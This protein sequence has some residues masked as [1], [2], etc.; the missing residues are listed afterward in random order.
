MVDSGYKCPC[1][2]N[3]DDAKFKLSQFSRYSSMSYPAKFDELN[4]ITCSNCCFSFTDYPV[5]ENV[6]G[7][8]YKDHYTGRSVKSS[9]WNSR[10]VRSKYQ[11][12]SRSIAQLS[13]ISQFFSWNGKKVLE[14]G[15]SNANLLID[16]RNRG[17]LFEAYIVEPQII[18]S[19]YYDANNINVVDMDVF[20]ELDEAVLEQKY[21]LV[22]MSHSLEHFNSDKISVVFNNVYKL[23]SDGGIFFV[24]VPNADLCKYDSDLER[25]APHLSFFSERSIH[26]FMENSSFKTLYSGAFGQSQ[27]DNMEEAIR[28]DNG[29]VQSEYEL[30]ST[31]EIKINKQTVAHNQAKSKRSLLINYLSS[32]FY[33][34]RMKGVIKLAKLIRVLMSNNFMNYGVREFVSNN[35]D[36]EFI[37]ILGRK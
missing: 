17:H 9:S 15:A 18:N 8:Y 35:P 22:I 24:E 1:C 36:G 32:L 25:M 14:I 13:L 2:S 11:Y 6:L 19:D 29:R 16:I 27:F 31:G 21:D 3:T 33:M 4:I 34:F 26:I 20:A 37:R 23:L 7:Y 10:Y 12:S 30:D 28:A 5:D